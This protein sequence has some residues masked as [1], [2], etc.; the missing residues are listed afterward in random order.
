LGPASYGGEL[1]VHTAAIHAHADL[2][3]HGHHHH[4]QVMGTLLA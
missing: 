4:H 3:A 1:F 2:A